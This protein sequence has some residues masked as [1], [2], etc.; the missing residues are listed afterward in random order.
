MNPSS[1][2]GALRRPTAPGPRACTQGFTVTIPPEDSRVGQMRR[3]GSA[4]LRFWGL[5]G[6]AGAMELLISE[7]VTNAIQHGSGRP[8]TVSLTR[9]NGMVR[10][11]VDNGSDGEPRERHPTPD[12]ESGRGLW[13]VAAT[14]KEWGSRGTAVWC[15][16]A[17]DRCA[18]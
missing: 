13:L 11:E 8:I 12:E 4:R 5:D 7:L 2:Q 9:E 10:L 18:P 1:A 6:L 16:L 15:T 14:S 3:L 17:A